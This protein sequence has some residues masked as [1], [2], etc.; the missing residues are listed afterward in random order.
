MFNP[1]YSD[2]EV[3]ANQNAGIMELVEGENWTVQKSPRTGGYKALSEEEAKWYEE[4]P[5]P[6]H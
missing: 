3:Q 2:T 6:Q 1:V 5:H 4:N